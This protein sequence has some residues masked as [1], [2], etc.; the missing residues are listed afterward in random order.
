MSVVSS[1]NSPHLGHSLPVGALSSLFGL[2]PTALSKWALYVLPYLTPT[3]MVCD[4]SLHP[5]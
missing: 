5:P 4:S 2:F 1:G 3:D